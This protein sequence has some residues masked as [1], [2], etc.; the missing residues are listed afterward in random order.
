MFS[1][2]RYTF[3]AIVRGNPFVAI[4]RGDP[5]VS[6]GHQGRHQDPYPRAERLWTWTGVVFFSWPILADI[7]RPRGIG[8][9]REAG[10][11]YVMFMA[12]AATIVLAWKQ[13]DA[14]R[15]RWMGIAAG[16]SVSAAAV[17]ELAELH[18]AWQGRVLGYAFLLFAAAHFGPKIAA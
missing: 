7:A 6:N 2:C 1:A 3:V 12:I 14:A 4:V 11:F 16:L 18:I 15:S 5:D 13:D 10:T 17:A 9:L 8:E